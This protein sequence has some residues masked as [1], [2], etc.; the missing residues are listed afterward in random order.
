MREPAEPSNMISN[1]SPR[2]LWGLHKIGLLYTILYAL[3]YCT[4]S[5]PS[6]LSVHPGEKSHQRVLPAILGSQAVDS[7]NRNA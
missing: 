5:E 7:V 2:V 6:D 4:Y 1:S 3:I